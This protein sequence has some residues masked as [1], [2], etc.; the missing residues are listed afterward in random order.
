MPWWQRFA[1]GCLAGWILVLAH[2][3][4]LESADRPAL[5]ITPEGSPIWLDP[6]R[7]VLFDTPAIALMVRNEHGDPVNYALRLWIFDERSRLKG[8]LDY[9]TRDVLDR[10]TRGRILIPLEIQGVTIRDRA[11]VT[12]MSASSARDAWRLQQSDTEQ[13]GAALSVSKDLRAD[14]SVVRFDAGPGEWS[15]PCEC[16]AIEALC[17]RHCATGRAT[18]ACT[19]MRDFGC[20]ASCTCK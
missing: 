13:F 20:S 4:A 14:L 8:T 12:V 7:A 6:Q 9:C 2:G 10:H 3:V 18:S 16:S 1:R 19:L 17:S 5:V 15:C 11:V